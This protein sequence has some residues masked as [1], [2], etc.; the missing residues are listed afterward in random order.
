MNLLGCSSFFGSYIRWSF[1][2]GNNLPRLLFSLSAISSARLALGGGVND[3]LQIV[4]HAL[5]HG[6]KG[7]GNVWVISQPIVEGRRRCP[8]R[9]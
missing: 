9:P 4:P 5:E 6:E 2:D 7:L 8:P 1:D 3:E